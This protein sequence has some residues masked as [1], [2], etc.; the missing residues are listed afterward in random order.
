MLNMYITQQDMKV[1]IDDGKFR[2]KADKEERTI[3]S[4]LIDSF[5][6]YGNVQFSSGALRHCLSKGIPVCFLF[7]REGVW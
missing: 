4:E 6:I 7:F 1:Y 2:F 3:P 5:T